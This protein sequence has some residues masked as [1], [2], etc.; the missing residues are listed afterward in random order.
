MHRTFNGTY[1]HTVLGLESGIHEIE[2]NTGKIKAVYE[3][4]LWMGGDLGW[5]YKI[6]RRINTNI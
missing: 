4:D 6:I 5:Y 3:I 2:F 1:L